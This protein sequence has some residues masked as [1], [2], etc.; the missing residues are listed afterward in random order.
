MTDA[1]EAGDTEKFRKYMTALLSSVSYRFQRK[2]D[3]MECERYF[4]YS[5]YLILQ[6]LGFYSTCAEKETSEGRINCVVECPDY[7]Y[8]MEFKLNGAAGGGG[9]ANQG[10]RLCPALCR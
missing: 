8:I 10:E 9:A 6:M 3:P 4:H 7:V 2:N 1:L 5:F